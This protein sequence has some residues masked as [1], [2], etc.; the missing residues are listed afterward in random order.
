MF[1]LLLF[2][3]FDCN[4]YISASIHAWIPIYIDTYIHLH[5]HYILHS[6]CYM[7][8]ITYYY[9]LHI[10][11]YILHYT[12]YYI[13]HYILHITLHYILHYIL[14]TSLNLLHIT[15]ITYYI[16]LKSDCSKNDTFANKVEKFYLG[17]LKQILG[18]NKKVNNIKV[19]AEVGQFPLSINIE[20]QMFT[21]ISFQ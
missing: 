5:I 14:H 9:I 10:T 18:V 3:I 13:L 7:L 15:Q 2:M 4:H 16:L 8:L 20:T 12:L 11:H 21:R 6:T 1:L 19:L 17:I